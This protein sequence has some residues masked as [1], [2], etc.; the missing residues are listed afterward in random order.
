MSFTTRLSQELFNLCLS[1]AVPV[2]CLP[3]YSIVVKGFF[4]GA[5]L[6]ALSGMWDVH[7][8]ILVFPKVS[9][10]KIRQCLLFITFS[11]PSCCKLLLD[12]VAKNVS[13]S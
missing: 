7:F 2:N 8:A 13:Y 12:V 3:L 10:Y 11:D 5:F 4:W 6:Y 1:V 9:R